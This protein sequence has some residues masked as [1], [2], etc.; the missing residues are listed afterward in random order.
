M[1][2]SPLTI[3]S[4]LARA[5]HDGQ[6]DKSG[7]PYIEH[8][9]RVSQAVRQ[10]GIAHEIAALLHDVVEDTSLTLADLA[11]IFPPFI[12]AAVDALT[13]RPNEPRTDYLSRV[14]ANDIAIVVKRADI[15]DN[16]SPERM[17]ALSE[18]DRERLTRKY[19]EATEYLDRYTS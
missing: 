18:S 5:A 9:I 4:V 11:L 2:P 6:T 17:A 7:Q 13:H 12:V 1:S 15:A 14:V 10:H 16:S 8:P 3:A 19:A